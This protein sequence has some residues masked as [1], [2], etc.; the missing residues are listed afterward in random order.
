MSNKVLPRNKI[1]R[2]H[3]WNAESVF[4]SD[5]AWEKEVNGSSKMLQG[6]RQYQ[7]RLAESPEVLLEALNVA[8]QLVSRAQIAFMYAG[9]SYNV[10]TTDQKAAGMFGKA[11]GM[12]GQVASAVSF[13]N[14]AIL[15]IGRE[16][17]DGWMSKSSK[18]AVYKHSFDDLFR[19]QAHVRSAEVEEILGLVSDPLG[20]ASNSTSMLTNAD[21]KF[22]PVKDE[23][24]AG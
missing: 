19:Q 2:K 8:E 24:G 22:K 15:A 17:L 10:D 20:G 13:L 4:P 9:F 7:G 11:Q 21:F 18:L 1:D 3:K 23:T 14:P 5:E 6:S 16:K 12:F